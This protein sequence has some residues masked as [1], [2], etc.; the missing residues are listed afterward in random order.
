MSVVITQG[1]KEYLLL[2]LND[3]LETLTTLDGAG[4][5]YDVQDRA[6]APKYTNQAGLNVGMQARCL[7][8]TTSGASPPW[9]EGEY[10]LY[11]KFNALPEVPRLGPF[12]FQVSNDG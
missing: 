8:D 12:K 5:T 9:E 11:I 4:L 10:N 1:S 2:E 3:E 6:G 7:I